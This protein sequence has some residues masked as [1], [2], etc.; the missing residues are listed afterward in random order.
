MIHRLQGMAYTAKTTESVPAYPLS[1]DGLSIEASALPEALVWG[2]IESYIAWRWAQRDVTWIVEGPGH[3]PMPL[4]PAAITTV[5]IWDG[6]TNAWIVDATALEPSPF[7]TRFLKRGPYRVTGTAGDD[8]APPA[9][10]LEAYR[11]LAEYFVADP[12][13]AGA[14]RED[15]NIG[16]ISQNIRRDPAWLGSALQNSGAADLLRRF[17]RA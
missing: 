11:R 7:G 17:R 16:G 14:D 4:T 6:T 1:G 10:V 9:I 2:R 8:T 5:E 13:T 3:W 15:V 12:G